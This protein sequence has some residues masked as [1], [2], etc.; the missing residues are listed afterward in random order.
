[1]I[2]RLNLLALIAL[3]SCSEPTFPPKTVAKAEE[4]KSESAQVTQ[5]EPALTPTPTPTPIPPTVQFATSSKISVRDPDDFHEMMQRNYQITQNN[6][7][8]YEAY[9]QLGAGYHQLKN[10]KMAERAFENASLIDPKKSA[11]L[12]ELGII[13]M[14]SEQF[15]KAVHT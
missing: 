14:E 12:L 6:P 15:A 11:P 13:Q 9:M 7:R 1:M 10:Y 2:R 5:A 4:Q 3:F 8:N